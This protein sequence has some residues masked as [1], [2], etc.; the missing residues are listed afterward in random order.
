MI[1]R[2]FGT[3][4]GFNLA[5]FSKTMAKQNS[6]NESDPEELMSDNILSKIP[7]QQIS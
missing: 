6:G 1:G 4:M 7:R 5:D 3:F 2:R